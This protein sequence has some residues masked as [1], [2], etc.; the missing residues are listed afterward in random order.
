MKD[1]Q[2]QTCLALYSTFLSSGHAWACVLKHLA[3][4]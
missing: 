2:N 3:V 1:D 4:L